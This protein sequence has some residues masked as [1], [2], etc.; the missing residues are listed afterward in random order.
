MDD[1]TGKYRD[2]D[3]NITQAGFVHLLGFQGVNEKQ[4]Q[5]WEEEDYEQRL[6]YELGRRTNTRGDDLE[7]EL[8][9]EIGQ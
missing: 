1:D 5:R 2:T 3:G 7:Q 6:N 9:R 4:E 8:E